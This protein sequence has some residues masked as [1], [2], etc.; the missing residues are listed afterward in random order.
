MPLSIYDSEQ[1][2]FE[3][4]QSFIRSRVVFTSLELQIFDLFSQ[5]NHG[6]TCAQVAEQLSLHYVQN[7]SRCLQD[8]LDCLKSMKFLEYEKEKFTYKLTDFARNLLLPNRQLLSN[9]DRDFYDKMPQL[10]ELV[11]NNSIKDSIHLIMLL[12]IK[13][14]VD[15]TAY[16]NVSIDSFDENVDVMVIWRQDGCLKEKIKQAY[17]ILPS[18]KASLLI[19]IIPNDEDDEV[20]LALNIL[21]NM[22]TTSKEAENPKEF[23]STKFFKKIGFQSIERLKSTDGIQLLLAY[24]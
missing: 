19:L 7:E 3:I 21:L 5:S 6:L 11:L 4:A 1:Y 15:L 9:I 2:L 17:D 23:Y 16:S 8:V 24:K 10:N 20:T 14:L 22:T 12:R 13:Q 18:S